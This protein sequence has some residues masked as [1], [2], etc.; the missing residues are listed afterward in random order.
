M[1]RLV[2]LGGRVR[3]EHELHDPRAV[4]QVDEDQPAVVAPA[5]YPAR[6]PGLGAGALARHLAAPRVAVL[7]RA[8]RVLH[9][10]R[11]PLRIVG[12]TSPVG[13]SRC[14]PDS[15]SLRLAAAPSP[16]I[17]T[18]RAPIRSACA[19]CRFSERP[20]SSSWAASPARRASRASWN[21]PG[22]PSGFAIAT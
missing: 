2:R 19:S 4:T 1:R 14:S 20:D 13:S 8:G 9:E 3:V 7:V 11:L 12:I 6:H 10:S 18:Y 22:A 5:V 17:A 21:A 15:I 16:M